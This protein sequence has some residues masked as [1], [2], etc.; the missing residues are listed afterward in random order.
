MI[1]DSYAAVP[2]TLP[3]EYWR[4][5]EDYE[6]MTK[7]FNRQKEGGFLPGLEP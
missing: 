5:P 3:A 2:V 1:E 4:V 6:N 7:T